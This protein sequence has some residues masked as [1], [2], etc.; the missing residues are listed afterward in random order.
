MPGPVFLQGE[1]VALR[2]IESEDV[3][4]LQAVINDPRV[5][6]GLGN[7]E[8]ITRTEEEEWVES[9]GEEEGYHFVIADGETPVGTTGLNDVNE[10]WGVT[11]AGYMVHPDHWNNGYATDAL[12]T[13][14]RFAFE[15]KRLRKVVAQAYG[16]NP[17]SRRVIEKAGFTEEGVLRNEAF[18]E[19]EPVDIHRYG[20]LEDEW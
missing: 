12:R 9:L 11:E 19:G 20:L 7:T 5:R 17:V 14:C 16:T 8:P 4:F 15:E 6:N 18:V 10:T 2:T 13:L 1:T 3:D